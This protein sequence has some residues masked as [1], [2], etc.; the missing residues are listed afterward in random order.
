MKI[1][2]KH[3][4]EFKSITW[5]TKDKVRTQSFCPL[6]RKEYKASYYS[7]NRSDILEQKSIYYQSNKQFLDEKNSSYYQENKKE[8][9]QYKA[10]WYQNNKEKLNEDRR[11]KY[12]TDPSFRLKDIFSS[13]IRHKLKNIGSSKNGESCLDYLPYSI[14]ELKEH[15]EKQ[16]ELWMTWDNWGVYDSKTWNDDDKSTWTWQIDHIIPQSN[17]PYSNMEEDNFRKCWALD[18]LRPLSSKSNILDGLT[19]VRHHK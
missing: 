12:N 1:C 14:Q 4:C 7:N 11:Y 13:S 16:F 10:A 3:N 9:T 5:T 8:I 19:K 18:N 6:C 17:L 15:L 2:E